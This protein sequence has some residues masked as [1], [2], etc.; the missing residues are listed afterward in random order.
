VIREPESVQPAQV[1]WSQHE[2][3]ATERQAIERPCTQTFVL[4][5]CSQRVDQDQI[6]IASHGGVAAAIAAKDAN[7]PQMRP[8]PALIITPF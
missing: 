5:A 2:S 8:L 6:K 4:R 1:G 7:T 3:I